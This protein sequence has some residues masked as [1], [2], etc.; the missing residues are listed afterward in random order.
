MKIAFS[1]VKNIAKGGGIEK[2]TE[3]LGSRLV[4]MG[5]EVLIYSMR[6]Y[7][8]LISNFKGM[9]IQYVPCIP[10]RQMQK[11]S[12]S[13]AAGIR[14]ALNN[15]PDIVHYHS[16]SPG[17]TAWMAK[18][19]GKKTLIQMHGLE[20]KRP[21]W[22]KF[23]NKVHWLLEKWSMFGKPN[24]TAVSK[25]QCDYFNK[26]YGIN[27]RYI[28]CGVTPKNFTNPVQIK[29]LNLTPRKYILFASRLVRDKGAHYL[30]P[31][32]RRIKTDFNLVIAGDVPNETQYKKKLLELAGDDNRIIFP[33]FVEGRLLEE[34]FSNAG[35]YVQP[36]EIEGLSIALLE[37]MSYGIPSL[38]SDIPENL[39]A[40]GDCGMAFKNKNIDDLSE[41]INFFIKNVNLKNT[42]SERSIQRVRVFYS[43]DSIAK[44]FANYYKEIMEK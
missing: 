30:I 7:G 43:W 13:Q 33:G 39:E 22:G 10:L 20:W 24:L 15:W 25:V 28:P 16:V 1:V 29:K 40:I 17:S 36:S 5:H 21:R 41:K 32:F 12:A 44:E 6:N 3:E 38:V 42:L 8:K 11:L 26:Q 27:A 2:Y 34:L 9:K 19:S 18:M 31:A 37:A 4:E 23:G 14:L 35:L